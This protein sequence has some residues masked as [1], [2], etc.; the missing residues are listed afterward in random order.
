MMCVL[1]PEPDGV[2]VDDAP[3]ADAVEDAVEARDSEALMDCDD[4]A[5][6]KPTRADTM[7]DLEKYMV[8]KCVGKALVR[9]ITSI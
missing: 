1:I 8:A 2:D 5:A 9:R 7:R 4:C 3:A 6:A